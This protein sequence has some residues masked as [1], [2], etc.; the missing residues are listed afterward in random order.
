MTE[1]KKKAPI[2][3]PD[4][5]PVVM[6]SNQE[7]EAQLE[8]IRAAQPKLVELHKFEEPQER[9]A[10]L[11]TLPLAVLLDLAFQQREEYR[12]RSKL[13]DAANAI[14]KEIEWRA[15]LKFEDM[16]SE[17]NPLLRA[18]GLL[19]SASVAEETVQNVDPNMW[20]KLQEFLKDEDLVYLL[21]KRLS[22]KA[23]NDWMEETGQILP[24][25]TLITQKKLNIRKV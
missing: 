21:Q 14:F 16:G 11:Q 17:E 19:C 6:M 5:K 7:F 24:G 15:L 3:E 25:V 12:L 8:A 20:P 1:E 18:G 22:S 23:V 10:F 9:I 2:P 4:L 13:A